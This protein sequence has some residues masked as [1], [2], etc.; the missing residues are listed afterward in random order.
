MPLVTFKDAKVAE[1]A[2]NVPVLTEVVVNAPAAKSPLLSL[3]T[4]VLGVLVDVAELT[5]DAT[6]VIVADETPPTLFTVAAFVTFAVPS[7][8]GLVYA[9]SPVVEIVLG[10]VSPLAVPLNVPAKLVDVTEL[11]PVTLV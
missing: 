2:V 10:V 3:L 1:V 4:S 6:V 7:N 8:A 11:S 5:D 9:T